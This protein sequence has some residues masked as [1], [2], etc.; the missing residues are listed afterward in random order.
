[1]TWAHQR[2][3]VIL[4]ELAIDCLDIRELHRHGYLDLPRVPSRWPEIRRIRTSRHLIYIELRNQVTPQQIHISWTACNFGGSRPWMHC[5]HCNQRV[6]RLFKGLSGY[7]C[8]AC[9]GNPP[10]ESQLRNEKA[11]T[12][13]KA[14]RLRSRLGGSK[15]VIHPIP[16]RPY[17]MWRRTYN[18]IVA[19]IERL[20]HPLR[21]SR[22]IRQA[23]L[24][25]RPLSY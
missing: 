7:F 4:E 8:R 13:L 11:R 22:I 20:E 19:E 6:A 18:R 17:R 21:G 1:M 12:Y 16:E 25:I 9:V 15:P 14:Y 24:W 10:Y 3:R 5:P 23:P 2:E